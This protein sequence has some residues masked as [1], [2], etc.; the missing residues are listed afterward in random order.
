MRLGERIKKLREQKEMSQEQIAQELFVTRQ[1]VSSWERSNSYPDLEM[2]LKLAE[3]FE[4]S[5]DELL[6]GD[7][8]S[9]KKIARKMSLSM[10]VVAGVLMTL[11][12]VGLGASMTNNYATTVYFTELK[13]NGWPEKLIVKQSFFGKG[14]KLHLQ[15]YGEP[16]V[17]QVIDLQNK[18]NTE[19]SVKLVDGRIYPIFTES[20]G[21]PGKY[22]TSVDI[23]ALYGWEDATDATVIY[24]IP[25][26]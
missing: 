11:S 5:L 23:G 2:T 21:D 19:I 20:I 10:K 24:P 13:D 1:T 4:V 9:V 15:L 17:Q 22:R 25:E 26:R 8:K 7:A 6:K 14:R 12:I 16:G 18:K 3:F